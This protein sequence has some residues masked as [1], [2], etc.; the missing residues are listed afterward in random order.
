MQTT[1]VCAQKIDGITLETN[2]MVIAVFLVTNLVNKVS[3]F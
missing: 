1:N 3:F 2:K